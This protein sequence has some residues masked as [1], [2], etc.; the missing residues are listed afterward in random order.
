MRNH[1]KLV[2]SSSEINKMGSFVSR[3]LTNRIYYIL[4]S[5]HNVLRAVPAVIMMD[6]EAFATTATKAFGLKI[7]TVFS[8]RRTVK[9]A[10]MTTLVSRASHNSMA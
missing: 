4:Q 5:P 9:P 7:Q 10:R 2:F 6:F 3:A 8:V 1:C